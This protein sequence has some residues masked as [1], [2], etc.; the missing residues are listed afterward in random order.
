MKKR[1]IFVALVAAVAL[2][3]WLLLPRQEQA[4][5]TAASPKPAAPDGKKAPAATA[6]SS[7]TVTDADLQATP[8]KGPVDAVKKRIADIR[9]GLGYINRPIEFYGLVIDQDGRPLSGVKVM[10]SA[11]HVIEALPG[12]QGSRSEEIVRVTDSTGRFSLTGVSGNDVS[13]KS[14]ELPGYELSPKTKRGFSYYGTQDIYKPEAQAPVVFHMWKIVGAE[15]LITADKFYG[16]VPDGRVYSIDVLGEKKTEGGN[17][18]DFKV[19]IRRPER[20]NPNAKYDWSC[21]IEGIGGGVIETRDEF[22]Y[23]APESGYQ[24]RYEVNVSANDPQWSDRAKRQLYVTARG[25]K[26]YARLDVEIFSNYQDKAV[27][28]V[29]YYAN[30]NG[31][32]NLEY[33][34]LQNV[35][36]P[37]NA[38]APKP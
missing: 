37:A 13:V 32:R 3:V 20:V 25:G 16:V 10:L 30:P 15:K 12:V 14:I 27:F 1:I 31:S 38:P 29:K 2:L 23:R 11:M 8:L 7:Q 18:G 6:P 28:S 26:V 5:I 33:D 9:A 17:A 34:P 4:P 35:A 24:P 22:M 21:T 19:S 36:K